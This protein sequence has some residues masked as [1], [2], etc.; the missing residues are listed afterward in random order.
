MSVP[1]AVRVRLDDSD[2][3]SSLLAGATGT[4]AIFT[5]H[6]KPA[7]VIRQV[8]LRQIAILNYINPF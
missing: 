8:L 2:F 5:E 3:A 1:L 6:I 4:A 7:H